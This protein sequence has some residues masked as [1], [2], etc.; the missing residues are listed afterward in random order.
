MN[1]VEEN[2]LPEEWEEKKLIDIVAKMHQ[3]INTAADK[4]RFQEKGIPILQT[5]NIT[6]GHIDFENVKLMSDN[7]WLKYHERYSPRENDI[8]FSNIGTIGKSVVV[9]KTEK[10]LIHWN[11][12]LLRLKEEIILPHYI[13]HYLDFLDVIKYFFDLQKGVTVH[14]V[15]KKVLSNTFVPTP[16]LS[17]QKRIVAKIDTLFA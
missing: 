3:G 13:K 6:K 8:L 7:D 11:I 17:E 16:P 1:S 15:S 12:F 5:R 14:F 4:V 2:T 10:Y 9:G